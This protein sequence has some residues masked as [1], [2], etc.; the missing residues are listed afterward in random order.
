MMGENY[1][2]YPEGMYVLEVKSQDF[3][4]CLLYT[5]PSPRD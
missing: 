2:K 4:S 1:A 5:S 3:C